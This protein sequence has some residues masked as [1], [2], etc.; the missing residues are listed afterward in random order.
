MIKQLKNNLKSLVGQT[1]VKIEYLSPKD[2]KKLFGWNY[3]PCEIHLS[4][5]V[6]LTPSCDDEGN[7]AGAIFTN[8]DGLATIPVERNTLKLKEEWEK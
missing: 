5:G 2:S 8:I 3:Q 1:I 7:N 6:I 4:N